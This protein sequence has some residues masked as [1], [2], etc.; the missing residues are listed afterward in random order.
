MNLLCGQWIFQVVFDLHSVGP[1]HSVPRLV[2]VQAQ[3]L[4]QARGEGDAGGEG[5][6]AAK[7]EWTYAGACHYAHPEGVSACQKP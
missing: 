6:S 5:T 3:L 1:L 7:A 2:A 4:Q